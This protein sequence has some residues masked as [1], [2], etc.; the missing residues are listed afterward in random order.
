MIDVR[1]N[2]RSLPLVLLVVLLPACSDP[3]ITLGPVPSDQGVTFHIH[4]GFAGAGQSVNADIRDLA[5][6]EGPC[7]SG[8]EGEKP[9]WA[10]CISSMRI[11]SGWKATLYEDKEFEG[12][13]VTLTTDTPDLTKVPGPCDGSFNDCVS[14]MKVARQ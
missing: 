8:A 7:T 11:V 10:D 2:A 5:K 13:S 3:L 9:T 12:R 1:I 14:S 4:A 6:V